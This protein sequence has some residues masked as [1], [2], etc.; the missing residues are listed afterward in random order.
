MVRGL[1]LAVLVSIVMTAPA[2]AQ[3]PE[4]APRAILLPDT[5]GANFA[6][7]DTLTGTS[8]PADFDFLVGTWRFTFQARLFAGLCSRWAELKCT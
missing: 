7:A 3:N 8:G 2:F 6:T 1:H 4:S 5:M